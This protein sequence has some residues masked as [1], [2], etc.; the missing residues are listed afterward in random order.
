MIRWVNSY[1]LYYG[2]DLY[3]LILT[4]AGFFLSRIDTA[5]TV[6]EKRYIFIIS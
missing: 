2:K 3:H 6:C 5:R 4:V 1:T